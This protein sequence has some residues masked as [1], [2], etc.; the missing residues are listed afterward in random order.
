M[1]LLGLVPYHDISK[2][3]ALY[4]PSGR[5]GQMFPQI[6]SEYMAAFQ[7][8][9]KRLTCK[10][11]VVTPGTKQDSSLSHQQEWDELHH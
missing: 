7:N 2:K 4:S 10:C 11:R 9:F 5:R 8:V 1:W 3:D 6:D